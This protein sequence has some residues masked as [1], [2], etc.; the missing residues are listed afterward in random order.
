[1]LVLKLWSDSHNRTPIDVFVYEPFDLDEE[2]EQAS[3]VA[4]SDHLEVPVV[5]L[6]TLLRMK[7]EAGR[8]Q[9]LADIDE[10]EKLA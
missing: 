1:M 3:K 2:L 9:D 10:L 6:P 4:L 8:P 7:R 5:S